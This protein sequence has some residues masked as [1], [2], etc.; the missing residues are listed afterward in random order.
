MSISVVKYSLG[1]IR[2][3]HR[4][5]ARRLVVGERPKAIKEALGISD[6]RFSIITSSPLFKVEVKKL[7][8]QRD[9]GVIDIT[10]T[11][12]ELSPIALEQIERT[13]YKTKSDSIRLQAAESILD[14]AGY[15]KITKSDV[16]VSGTINHS[17]LT[18][19]EIRQLI[20][21][22][23]ERMRNDDEV[24]ASQI[25][26]AESIEVDFTEPQE[27]V[28]VEN[29]PSQWCP[30]DGHEGDGNGSGS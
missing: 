8:V 27:N 28:E 17:S 10:K 20:K 1:E 30:P 13:M 12:K 15:S 2:P 18:K 14:R 29:L 9:A 7:E 26:D 4:E 21:D 24:V 23:L 5:I 6:S 3:F 25:S 11:L 16:N 22:R 19:D